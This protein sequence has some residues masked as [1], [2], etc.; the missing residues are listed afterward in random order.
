MQEVQEL[1]NS[2]SVLTFYLPPYSP[3]LNPIELTF[4]YIKHYLKQHEDIIY[5]ISP[6][7]LIKAAFDSKIGL[8]IVDT[9]NHNN[10]SYVHVVVSL[11]YTHVCLNIFSR[12]P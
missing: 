2:A 5:T 12:H 8:N 6:H 7:T 10:Y 9:N 3:D 1:L 11:D 4:S